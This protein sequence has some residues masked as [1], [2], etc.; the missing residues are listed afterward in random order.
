MKLEPRDLEE[1]MREVELM[2]IRKKRRIDP[3]IRDLVIGLRRWGINT[4]MSC[5]G[6]YERFPF[7]WIDISSKDTR[8]LL[9]ICGWYNVQK[10]PFLETIKWVILPMTWPSGKISI[11]LVPRGEESLEKLQESAI[12]FGKF[13]QKLPELP[14]F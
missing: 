9:A 1:V 3:K 5:Q 6:D 11:R 2:E 12:E 7:P 14:L 4:G 13:L 10:R 8:K